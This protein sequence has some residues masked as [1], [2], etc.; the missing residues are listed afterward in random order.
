NPGASEVARLLEVQP[1]VAE[2]M[3]LRQK[4]GNQ[5][6]T[7]QQ[8]RLETLLLEK[9]IGG[10]LEVRKAADRID[11]E[12]HYQFDVVLADLT[13]RRDRTLR[14]YT[15]ANF[16]KSGI[17]KE[18][19]VGQFFKGA[20]TPGSDVLMVNTAG[21]LGLG[22]LALL[23]SGGGKRTIDAEPNSL[24]DVLK[25][26]PPPEA[27]CTPLMWNYMN[28]VSAAGTTTRREEIVA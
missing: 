15:T 4:Y 23:A 8:L 18:I 9:A 10:T 2:L 28:S 24:A 3:D 22:T 17:L 7:V 19:A 6:T 14:N 27:R 13:G 21:N 26:N 12:K 25:L 11:H 5:I 16:L 20:P 1:Q